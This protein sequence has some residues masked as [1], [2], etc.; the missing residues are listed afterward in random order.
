MIP[1]GRL[2][3][4]CGEVHRA[5]VERLKVAEDSTLLPAAMRDRA[6]DLRAEVDRC[7]DALLEHESTETL[8]GFLDTISP[9]TLFFNEVIEENNK[10]I[11]RNREDIQHLHAVLKHLEGQNL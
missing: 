5:T 6:A 9:A 2:S 8:I 3:E 10:I 4:R 11:A 7:F 1:S